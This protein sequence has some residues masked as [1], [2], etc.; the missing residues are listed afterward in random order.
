MILSSPADD[1]MDTARTSRNVHVFE[2]DYGYYALVVNGS[3]IYSIGPESARRL[4]DSGGVTPVETLGLALPEQI[5]GNGNL[6]KITLKNNV[7]VS[8]E[9][10]DLHSAQYVI[11]VNGPTR[12]T[13]RQTGCR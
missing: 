9:R 1:A 2:T 5:V 12:L 10:R 13:G 4:R 8:G 3:R 7:L 11:A 6:K